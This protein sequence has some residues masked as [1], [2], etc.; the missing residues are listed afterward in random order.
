MD[1]SCVCPLRLQR[2]CVGALCVCVHEHLWRPSL[3]DCGRLE[4]REASSVT[5]LA[6]PARRM[7][8]NDRVSPL[9]TVMDAPNSVGNLG[10]WTH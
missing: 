1:W 6:R 2:S 9:T 8:E 3:C 5:C 10:N 4:E 7:Q